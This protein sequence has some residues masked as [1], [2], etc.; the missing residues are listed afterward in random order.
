MLDASKLDAEPKMLDEARRAVRESVV[1]QME[2]NPGR[3]SQT[4]FTPG[5]HILGF[6]PGADR[7]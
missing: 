7:G 5:C 1:D 6:Q 2:L 3:R 4:R